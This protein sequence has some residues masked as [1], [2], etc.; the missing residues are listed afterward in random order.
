[1]SARGRKKQVDL[2][3][4]WGIFPS[5]AA[6]KRAVEGLRMKYKEPTG[7]PLLIW[8]GEDAHKIRALLQRHPDEDKRN[9]HWVVVAATGIRDGDAGFWVFNNENST[10]ELI[11]ARPPLRSFIAG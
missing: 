6:A 9:A 7:K 2:G 5:I 8:P 3:E 4:A 10:Y 1:M 11:T